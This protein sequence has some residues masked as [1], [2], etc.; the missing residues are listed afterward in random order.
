MT[1][2]Q[3]VT[4]PVARAALESVRAFNAAIDRLGLPA[5][6]AACELTQLDRLV[7]RY[8]E[9]ARKSLQ[10]LEQEKRSRT[11]VSAP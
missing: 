10:L 6:T 11:H 9:A 2:S 8:P 7:R 5:M 4:D 3:E 1:E